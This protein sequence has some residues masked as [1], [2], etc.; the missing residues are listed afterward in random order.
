MDKSV[1][2]SV[3]KNADSEVEAFSGNLTIRQLEVFAMASRS[4]TFS[5]GA[6]RLGISQ[7]SL[8]NTI[9]KIEQHLGLRLFDRTTRTLS[10]TPQGERLAIVADDL[11]RTFQASLSNIHEA[12]SGSRGRMSM[13]VIP[14]VGG[15][16]TAHALN[17]FYATY[18]DFDVSVHD[19]SGAQG[20][21]WVLD[22]VVDFGIIAK[23]ANDSELNTE[24]VHRDDVQVVCRRDNPLASHKV[25]S[26]K[27]VAASPIILAGSG[28]IRRDI[29]TAW[30]TAGMAIR[31]RFEVE[32]I[33]TA[34]SMVSAGLGITILPGLFRPT[35]LHQELL[36]LP[37][38]FQINRDIVIIRRADRGLSEPLG[39]MLDC[40]R[41]SFASY[42]AN[43]SHHQRTRA[44]K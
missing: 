44:K 2:K 19:I 27:D 16:V 7:P 18:P 17:L 40:F 34:L 37:S 41:Q 20:M 11:V 3:A 36:S 4:P 39:H 33:M 1:A 21:A 8:S 43:A 24:L 31:P 35:I 42:D 9:A 6:K 26:W 13:A 29:E 10:L 30:L 14:S 5:E 23:P 32:Q 25:V 22:R 38:R 15:S 28:V 12:A